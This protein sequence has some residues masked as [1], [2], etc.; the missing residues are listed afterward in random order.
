[1]L[2]TLQALNNKNLSPK[3]RFAQKVKQDR[4]TR[5]SDDIEFMRF[6]KKSVRLSKKL[7]DQG[8]PRAAVKGSGIDA[9]RIF[10]NDPR[11]ERMLG[12]LKQ[13]GYSSETFND[14]LSSSQGK[15][16][17]PNRGKINNL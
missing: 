6:Q 2:K 7:D 10:A 15:H 16:D 12:Y 14:Y 1:M 5:R 8:I 17:F 3:E 13:E 11:A 9:T 4:I